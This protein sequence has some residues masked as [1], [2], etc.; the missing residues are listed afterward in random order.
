MS[1]ASADTGAWI[2]IDWG[3]TQMRLWH[4]SACGEVLAR[5]CLDKGMGQIAPSDYE[6][7]L[8]D[9]ARPYLPAVGAI[10]VIICGMAGSRQGWREAPYAAAPCLPPMLDQAVHVPTDDARLNVHILPGIKQIAPDDVMRG[11]ETQI[12]GVLSQKPDFTGVICLPGTHTKWALIEN[13]IVARFVTFMS[14]ELFSVIGQH[15]VLRHSVAADGWSAEAFEAAC[16]QG[17]NDP[18]TLMSSLFS[19]RAQS[20][21]SGLTGETARA[22]LS[23]LLLG[24][25]MSAA[26][27]YW[28]GKDVVLVGEDGLSQAYAAALR[29]QDVAPHILDSEDTTLNGLRKAQAQLL[30]AHH[31]S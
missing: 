13:G 20:L 15:S 14:G 23:G 1:R 5:H 4:M 6:P 24:A 18:N 26:R 27:A 30:K 17:A 3:T 2:A 12:A 19:L 16:T 28:Q 21:L 22:T 31:D 7:I 9:V 29:T 11:E 25:E 8:L 10:D